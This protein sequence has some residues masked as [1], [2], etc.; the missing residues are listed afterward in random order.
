MIDLKQDLFNVALSR[1]SREEKQIKEE[2][3]E[4]RDSSNQE[5]KSSMGD[6]YE[7]GRELIAGELDKAK[8]TLEE[9]QKKINYLNQ[10][11]LGQDSKS[12]KVGSLVFTDSGNFWISISFGEIEMNQK[13]YFLISPI[14]PMGAAL[15]GKSKGD[16]LEFRG[17]SIKIQSVE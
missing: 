15:L 3:Q 12:I 8:A 17:R 11:Q 16:I 13:K 7:T 9:I 4:L 10:I 14:S 5:T 2:I 1:L 6:K